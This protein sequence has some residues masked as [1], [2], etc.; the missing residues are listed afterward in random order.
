MK[1]VCMGGTFDVFHAG[2][3]VL[4]QRALDVSEH[5]LIGLTTDEPVRDELAPSLFLMPREKADL[6]IG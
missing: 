5:V 1:S 6:S 2:H 3:E 4:I